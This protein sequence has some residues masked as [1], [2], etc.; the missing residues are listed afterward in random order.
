[1]KKLTRG[2]IF[3]CR[4][5]A[6]H[7]GPGIRTTVFLKGCPFAC[8]W[9]H[10]PESWD[11]VPAVVYRPERCI[12]C[13]RCVENCTQ[14][15]L[16]LAAAGVVRETSLCRNCADCVQS[17]PAEARES[18]G[19]MSSDQELLA[20]IEKDI[21]FYDQSG[22]GVT[23]SGGEPL[24]QVD[25]LMALLHGCK[26][27]EI[28]RTVDTTGFAPT[29][30]VAAVSRLSDLFLYDLKLMDPEKH[31]RFTGHTNRLILENLKMLSSTGAEIIIRIPL[32]PGIND[33][34]D[35]IQRTAAF[36]VGLPRRHPVE[37]LAFHHCAAHKYSKLGL[38][39][40]AQELRPPVPRQLL[41]AAGDL[42]KAGLTVY[43]GGGS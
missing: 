5:F 20:V 7:D 33:D 19:W 9:C 24:I 8:R 27:R 2:T 22:G 40:P 29:E 10:N 34:A 1:M 30:T 13:S 42:R 31:R 17:C 43:T 26:Q 35:N 3:D 4:R 28:H 23:F 14:G 36:V 37:L 21:P 39:Y 41:E 6:T 25:F 18:T 11:A 38:T 16:R 12:G 32:I 15:A